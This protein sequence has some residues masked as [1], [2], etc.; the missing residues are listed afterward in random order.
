EAATGSAPVEEASVMLQRLPSLGRVGPESNDR[1]FVDIY[2]LDGLRAKDIVT[3]KHLS[4]T[5]EEE[6]LSAK[7]KNPLDDLG[8]RV[9][10]ADSTL[11]EKAKLE[12]AKMACSKGNTVLTSDLISSLL[13][14]SEAA[15]DFEAIHLQNGEILYLP[16]D[17][18]QILNLTISDSYIGE[19]SLPV[20]S[21]TNTKITNCIVIKVTGVSSE[22][23]LPQ[24][25]SRLTIDQ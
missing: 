7:W 16:L 14:Q 19:I 17:E 21:C 20:K 10:A 5:D 11:S 6:V 8:Q 1:Q 18:R 13:R 25:F 15:F 3:I 23:A 2:I 24:W 12:L 22:A 9:L 4:D